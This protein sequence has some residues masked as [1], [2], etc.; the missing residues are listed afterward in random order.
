[1]RF[2]VLLVDR[3]FIESLKSAGYKN[4]GAEDLVRVRDHGVDGEYIADMKDLGYAPSN[5]DELVE[6]RDQRR[7]SILHQIN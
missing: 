3:E 4:L 2:A 1:M 6:S 5:L 7:G